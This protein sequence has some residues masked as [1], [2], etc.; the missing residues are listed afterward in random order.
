MSFRAGYENLPSDEINIRVREQDLW[1]STAGFV[2]PNL[3]DPI[4]TPIFTA[5]LGTG[6][7][8]IG[9]TTISYASI[10]SAIATTALTIGLQAAMMPKPPKPEKGKL[11]VQQAIPYRIWGVGRNRTSGALMLWETEGPNLHAIHAIRAHKIKSFNRFWLHDDEVTLSG[12][13]F[14]SGTERYTE[15]C[16][17]AYRL[18]LPTETP[19]ATVVAAFSS[20]GLWTNDHR[21][22][23]QASIWFWASATKQKDQLKK[24]PYGVP[25]LSVETDDAA[26]WDPRDPAQDPDDPDTWMWTQNTV[27]QIIWWLCFSEFG[28]RLDYHKAILPVL[29]LWIEEAD[30]CDEDI[31]NAGGGTHKRYQSSVWDTTENDPKAALNA[32]LAACDGHLVNRGD[33]ARILTVGKFRESRCATLTDRDIIGHRIDYDV[34]FEDEIN[35]LVPTFNYPDTDYTTTDTD[36]FEDVE[37][38]LKAGRI[39]SAEADYGAVQDWRQARFLGSREWKRLLQKVRGQLDIRLS[40][41]NAIYARWIRME[42]PIRLP[43]LDGKLIENR[44]SILAITKGGFTMDMIQHPENIDEWNPSADEGT[45]PPVPGKP[46]A[47]GV[48][49]PVINLVQ[50]KPNGQSVYLRVVIIDP[51]DSSLT[52]VVRYRLANNGTGNPGA[53]VGQQFPDAVASGGFVELNTNVVPSD[54]DLE[55]QVYFLSSK[56]AAGDPSPTA[57]VRSTVDPIAPIAL[58]SFTQTASAPHLGNAV[59]SIQTDNDS[60][61]KTVKLY[62]KASGVPLDIEADTPIWVQ[63]VV[64][65]S[66]YS[67]TDGDATRSN[68]VVNGDFA[69]SSG[70]TLGANITISG[71]TANKASAATVQ[72]LFRDMASIASGKTVRG[73]FDIPSWTSGEVRARF[74]NIAANTVQDSPPGTTVG[75]HLF[76][77]STTAIRDRFGFRFDAA[78]VGSIDNAVAYEETV[79]CAPQGTF[80][81]YAV[82]FNQSDKEG[83][84]S[85]PVTVTII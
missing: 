4:F 16:G 30:I 8:T 20:I 73:K 22:D 10:A 49:T 40:G 54:Q 11:P 48:V 59:F 74:R 18:G 55:V 15:Q 50:A 46:A 32:L 53:W 2:K 61:V 56:G 34:L 72:E 43:R 51:E 44:R 83:P 38:Q 3:R 47:T 62:R 41:I 1:S 37:A 7:F 64:A 39:L 28:F 24:F 65:S 13:T 45:Q 67:H 77:I 66:S 79:S 42:T 85:G 82:P 14:H 33:G 35:R 60:H 58:V 6:G 75:E 21:G 52:P 26:C 76:S 9:A 57:E 23:G 29:D 17:A 84:V 70:W 71:G 81:Y 31:P 69:S 78:S 19:Y 63:E 36:Y 68:S 27:L 25:M 5:I 12:G 80:D